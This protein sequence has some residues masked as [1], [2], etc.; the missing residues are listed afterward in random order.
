LKEE[1]VTLSSDYIRAKLVSF[2][3]L[4][5]T[6][7]LLKEGVEDLGFQIQELTRVRED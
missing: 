4:K 7:G 2:A 1:G 5:N 6:Q 3:R